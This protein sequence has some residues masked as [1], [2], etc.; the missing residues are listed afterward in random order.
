MLAALDF[1]FGSPREIVVVEGGRE[2]VHSLVAEIHRRFIPNKV[3]MV[4]SNDEGEVEEVSPL[5]EGK[6]ALEGKATAY[7]CQNYTCKEPITDPE[8]L[9]SA[10]SF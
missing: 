6:K 9:K 5:A 7:I 3:L 1:L 2:R 10:L 8:E 4:L